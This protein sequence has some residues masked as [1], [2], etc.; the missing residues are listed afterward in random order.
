MCIPPGPGLALFSHTA[1]TCEQH[2]MF[3]LQ[4]PRVEGGESCKLND[5]CTEG[6]QPNICSQGERKEG[7]RGM[8]E[9]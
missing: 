3:F 9:C 8:G 6:M 2:V 7:Q 1:L 5:L 4:R